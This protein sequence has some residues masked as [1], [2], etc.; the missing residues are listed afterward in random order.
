[1]EDGQV[2]YRDFRVE[3]PPAALP[4]FLVPAV[5]GDD[6]EA[7]FEALMTA[8]GVATVLLVASISAS[9]FAPLFVAV[10]PLLLGSVF[11]SRF[12]LWPVTLSLAAL[13]LFLTGRPRLGLGVLGVATAAKVYPALLAPILLAHVWRTR[14]RR[15]ALVCGGVFLVAVA[16]IVLPFTVVSP[17]GVWDAFWVQ[18]GRPLQI[19]TLG[20][21]LLLAAHHAF[22]LDLTMDSS[23]GSQ[24]LEGGAADTLAVVSTLLQIAAVVAVWVWYARGPAERDRLLRACAAAVCAFVVFG[25]VLSPQF[26]IWLIPLVPLVRGRRGLAASGVLAL[27]LVLTQLWFPFRYWELA[28]E[29]DTAASWLVLAR[30][31]TLVALLAVLTLRAPGARARSS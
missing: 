1:M 31:L 27:A 30:D 14:G 25:K 11:L 22:G 3:Y 8:L 20:A 23:H 24:N 9:W 2:P 18:A 4:V 7:T 19:E 28:L 13:A 17:G 16:L 26:L 15:E 6:Y 21:G 10:A 5:A 12:D 29:F